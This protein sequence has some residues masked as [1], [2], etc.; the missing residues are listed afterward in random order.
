MIKCILSS[1]FE[2][3]G[4][5]AF[6]KIYQPMMPVEDTT[7]RYA[8]ATPLSEHSRGWSIL[9]PKL[10]VIILPKQILFPTIGC[11]SFIENF[12]ALQVQNHKI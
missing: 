12:K 8:K 7:A 4:Y 1:L 3:N 9:V 5:L 11:K 10:Y 6:R 2:M